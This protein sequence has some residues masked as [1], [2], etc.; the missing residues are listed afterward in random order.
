[1][2][3]IYDLKTRF[4]DLL[5]PTARVL[6]RAGVRPNA[7]TLAAL[8]GSVAVGGA[9]LGGRNHPALL[10]LLPVWL[11]IRMALNALDGMLAR[12]LHLCSRLGAV[13]N[14]FGDV[15]S[16]LALYLP[17]A[18]VCEPAKWPTVTFAIGAV[19]TE[20][21]GVLAAALGAGRRY[22]GPM[23]KSDRALLIGLLALATLAAPALYAWWIWVFSVAT[24][25]AAF[26]CWNR[27][28]GAIH[29]ES[30]QL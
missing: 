3:S 24:A 23:G 9:L 22:E 19:L 5:R 27:L 12:E 13:L 2:A 4:Q 29:S 28:S 30:D 6:A 25:L 21:S 11:F 17:L 16:D 15:V 10:L 7:V 8:L 1:M 26:T 18:L 20:F 14:E